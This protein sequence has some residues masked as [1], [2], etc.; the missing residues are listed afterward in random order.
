MKIETFFLEIRG[1]IEP[2]STLI[3]ILEKNFEKYKQIHLL[4]SNS[5]GGD[6]NSVQKIISL[7]DQFKSQGGIV[8]SRAKGR[9]ASASFLLY[10]QPELKLRSAA[11]D[12]VFIID[13]PFKPY[14]KQLILGYNETRIELMNL[15]NQNDLIIKGRQAWAKE[16]SDRTSLSVKEVFAFEGQKISFF[17]AQKYG[18]C[19]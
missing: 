4:I 7:L 18:I 14:R 6:V 15:I 10:L 13:L 19:K 16:I 12:V 17:E 11:K 5:P 8:S 2:K 3:K 1:Q 9:V